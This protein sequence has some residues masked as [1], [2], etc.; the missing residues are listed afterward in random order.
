MDTSKILLF[1]LLMV[2]SMYL[3]VVMARDT[4]IEIYLK[5]LYT[6]CKF[7]AFTSFSYIVF[8]TLL[9]LAL[10]QFTYKYAYV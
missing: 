1:L 6:L 5:S 9:K 3:L 10:I 4:V 8:V 7:L 2:Y